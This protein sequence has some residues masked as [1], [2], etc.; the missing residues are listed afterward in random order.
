MEFSSSSRTPKYARIEQERR[1]LL[2]HLPD[3]FDPTAPFT[4]I[5]DRYLNGTRLRL[6]RMTSQSG[7]LIYKLGQK[8]RGPDHKPHQTFMTNLYL[9]ENEYRLFMNLPAKE[10][11]KRRYAYAHTQSFYSL[12]IFEKHLNGLIL[13]EIES[14]AGEDINRL[15]LPSFAYREV[16]AETFFLGGNLAR[17]S[18]V[19]FEK[20]LASWQNEKK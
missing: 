1:F 8:Y 4:H 10:L 15:P 20:Q 19:E 13:A 14:R 7:K 5:Y 2:H 3:D 9:D 12:D 18:W 17:L 6:R 16:T 11:F